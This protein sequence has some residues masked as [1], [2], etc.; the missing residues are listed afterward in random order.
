M[1]V[2]PDPQSADLAYLQSITEGVTWKLKGSS[3]YIAPGDLLDTLS[4]SGIA[5]R[6][7]PNNQTIVPMGEVRKVRQLKEGLSQSAA[8]VEKVA[9]QIKPI[10][11]EKK[12]EKAVSHQQVS[13]TGKDKDDAEKWL[14]LIKKNNGFEG[15]HIIY[16]NLVKK[17][18]DAGKS[19]GQIELPG[20]TDHVF[21]FDFVIQKDRFQPDQFVLKV[22]SGRDRL[23]TTGGGYISFTRE[24]MEKFLKE[25][26][27]DGYVEAFNPKATSEE[28]AK[29]SAISTQEE[30]ALLPLSEEN[31][32]F[33]DE[34]LKMINGGQCVKGEMERDRVFVPH[35]I[36][37]HWFGNSRHWGKIPSSHYMI[38][39]IFGEK[40][41]EGEQESFVVKIGSRK[42]DHV[43]SISLTREQLI[44]FVREMNPADAERQFPQTEKWMEFYKN[45]IKGVHLFFPG[46]ESDPFDIDQ[47]QRVTEDEF[48]LTVL[49]IADKKKKKI[50]M[51]KMNLRGM[52]RGINPEAFDKEFSKE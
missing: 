24:E 26:D 33:V 29:K 31:Q 45:N 4:Q 28:S 1:T 6:S 8:T 44:E 23:L 51:N 46:Y 48:M 32:K 3:F 16:R 19:W 17:S 30:H 47:I 52:L 21:T 10:E 22:Y 25:L 38:M 41:R 18:Q 49:A 37:R 43:G 42:S 40:V 9:Q 13:L 36:K 14:Q 35:L 34:C 7:Y 20:T 27:P 5:A 2:Q 12:V 11:A 15:E 39:G 50:R